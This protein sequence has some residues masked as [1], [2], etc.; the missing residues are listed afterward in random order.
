M[1]QSEY[2]PE[3]STDL[4]WMLQS[5]QVDLATLAEALVH[6]RYAP[7]YRLCLAL[8]RDDSAALTATLDT[9]GESLASLH[10]YRSSEGM[11]TWLYRIA[12]RTCRTMRRSNPKAPAALAA[13]PDS[14]L[15]GEP[16]QGKKPSEQAVWQALDNLPETTHLALLATSLLGMSPAP[17]A[18]LLG[19]SE[20]RL[21]KLLEQAYAACQMAMRG[22]EFAPA[23]S[24]PHLRDQV[25]EILL[26]RWPEPEVTPGHLE[27]VI[28]TSLLAAE[29]TRL[30]RRL[31]IPL[32]EILLIAPI[33]LLVIGLVWGAEK[34]LPGE[35]PDPTPRRITVLVQV[36]E[37][38]PHP[39][40]SPT[41]TPQQTTP[42]PTRP[43]Y[44]PYPDEA[45]Y[46]VLPGDTL[47]VLGEEL[48]FAAEEIRQLNRLPSGVKLEPGSRL[49][50]PN[51]VTPG[52]P[53]LEPTRAIP[54]PNVPLSPNSSPDE[55]SERVNN[56][57]T[58]WFSMWM[59]AVI[60]YQPPD[61]I[62]G[63]EQA[64]R[65]QAWFYPGSELFIYGPAGETPSRAVLMDS[66]ETLIARPGE[67]INW[68]TPLTDNMELSTLWRLFRLIYPLESRFNDLP[69]SRHDATGESTLIAGRE[70]IVIEL[71]EPFQS[72][73]IR[74]CV[75]IWTGAILCQQHYLQPGDERPYLEMNVRS[76]AYAVQPPLTMI[77]PFLPWRG[78]Y[79]RSPAGE[80]VPIGVPDLKRMPA[81]APS[82]LAY[83]PLPEGYDLGGAQLSVAYPQP[84]NILDLD[85]VDGNTPVLLYAGPHL[86]GAPGFSNPIFM[87][88]T[89]SVDGILIA[90]ANPSL[91]SG[92]TADSTLRWFRLDNPEQQL[93]PV[94]KLMPIDYAISPD[95]ST[96]AVAGYSPGGS[97]GLFL[98]DA[99]TGSTR[100]LM[101]ILSAWS[102]WWSPDGQ[103]LAFIGR[104]SRRESGESLFVVSAANGEVSYQQSLGLVDEQVSQ[105][106]DWVAEMWGDQ[107][108]R[109]THGLEDC[110]RPPGS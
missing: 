99:A 71:K 60:Q 42:T 53:I 110:L 103:Q 57:N 79:A 61:G 52:A 80:P 8:L 36:P 45:Y 18:R 24:N 28:Q 41:A 104:Q 75:D 46:I 66:G 54:T 88:C 85:Q 62:N 74:Y 51:N 107:F 1:F 94:Q 59:D 98:V 16:S 77:D 40:P 64:Y 95:S 100:Y 83:N 69:N 11:D 106:P 14:R 91:D 87:T 6:A 31:A 38:T 32:K 7:V 4:E 17:A 13:P 34:L 19:I 58:K 82:L 33:L 101:R 2:E 22:T 30:Q 86:L 93:E 26:H 67:G 21:D 55:I 23:A 47:G 73:R 84:L 76:I 27:Q 81:Q 35:E 56:Q 5:G 105:L 97:R 96:L 109:Q 50:I 68:F 89:R 70:A 49:L 20:N 65:I 39:I 3:L 78:G 48:G 108:P 72:G 15:E 92:V 37:S 25:N 10:S 12:L 90:Y 63:A 9:F 102:I 44:P 29:T 43:Y